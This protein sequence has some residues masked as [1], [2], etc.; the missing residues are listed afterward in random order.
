[1]REEGEGQTCRFLNM[2]FAFPGSKS[3]PTQSLD[4]D[5]RPSSNFTSYL[6]TMCASM[7]FISFATK[8]RPGLPIEKQ[9]GCRQLWSFE[10]LALTRRACRVRTQ[11]ILDWWR[12][13]GTCSLHPR[14]RAWRRTATGRIHLR[15]CSFQHRGALVRV[16]RIGSSRRGLSG[17][18]RMQRA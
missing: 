7:A 17:H 10:M 16:R 1:M 4:G 11:G 6:T 18:S 15:S 12:L 3:E 13:V 9:I 8:N 2:T 14:P 5:V